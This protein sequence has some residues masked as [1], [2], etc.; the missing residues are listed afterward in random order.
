LVILVR[1]LDLGR[2]GQF[3]GTSN[4]AATLGAAYALAG[5]ADEALR[6]VAGAVEEF[7]RRPLHFWPAFI[8]LKAWRAC[9]SA[10]RTDEAASHARETL[11]LTRRL[12][13]RGNKAH[14]LCLNGDL[15]PQPAARTL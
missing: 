9:L 4:A 1:A 7:H 3:I 2:T 11:S 13:A 10:G 6:L 5:R 8:L 15:P 14:A 12:G